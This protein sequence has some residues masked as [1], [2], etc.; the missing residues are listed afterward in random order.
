MWRGAFERVFGERYQALGPQPSSQELRRLPLLVEEG[1]Q[2]I[3]RF[4]SMLAST[5]C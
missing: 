5:V 1:D 4:S 3:L 2:R